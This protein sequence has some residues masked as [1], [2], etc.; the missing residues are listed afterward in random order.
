MSMKLPRDPGALDAS[1]EFSSAILHQGTN[2]HLAAIIGGV[3]LIAALAVAICW[4]SRVL[5]RGRRRDQQSA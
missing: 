4:F 3:I 5:K 1:P 2:G